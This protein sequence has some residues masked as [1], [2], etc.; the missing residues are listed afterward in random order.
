M[1]EIPSTMKSEPEPTEEEQAA[2]PVKKVVS[3]TMKSMLFDADRD[4]LLEIYAPWCGHCQ[5]MD[6]D[7]QKIGKKVEK[8]G[9]DDILKIVKLDGSANDSAIDSISWSGFP[10]LMYIK[11]GTETPMPYDGP[12]TSKGMWKWI[13]NNHSKKEMLKERIEKKQASMKAAEAEARGEKPE[14]KK[15]EKVEEEAKAEDKHAEL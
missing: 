9:H 2:S 15:E 1:D 14:E 3:T 10:T 8:D 4:V 6:P 11:A 7:Y 5:Q 12:R 13:K